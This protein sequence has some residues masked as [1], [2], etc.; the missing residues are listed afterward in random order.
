METYPVVNIPEEG[1]KH[2]PPSLARTATYKFQS[3]SWHWHSLCQLPNLGA[4]TH[5]KILTFRQR[6]NSDF[7]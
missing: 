2:L 4:D 1:H 7:R 3:L 6:V 5:L